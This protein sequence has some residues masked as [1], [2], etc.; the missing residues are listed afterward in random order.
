MGYKP[1]KITHASD[2][3]GKLYEYAKEL[4]KKGKAFVCGESIEDM[5][6]NRQNSKPSPFRDRPVE[7]NLKLFEEMKLGLYA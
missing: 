4:I 6:K 1:W 2:L 5:R 3:F 7:E